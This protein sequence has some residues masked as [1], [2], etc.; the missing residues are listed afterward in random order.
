MERLIY[1]S[2]HV[3]ADNRAVANDIIGMI[4]RIEEEYERNENANRLDSYFENSCYMPYGKRLTDFYN[5]EFD[6]CLQDDEVRTA[7]WEKLE[8]KGIHVAQSATYK[9][10]KSTYTLK[11]GSENRAEIYKLAFA[12]ELDV[13]QTVRLFNEV[14]LDR[15]CNYRDYRE[16]VY[17]YCISRGKTYQDAETIIGEIDAKSANDEG[18]YGSE[19]GS[20]FLQDRVRET[21]TDGDIVDFILSH[22]MLFGERYVRARETVQEL[23]FGV[24]SEDTE[25]ENGD[26]PIGGEN[27][28]V[29]R[30]VNEKPKGSFKMTRRPKTEGFIMYVILYGANDGRVSNDI[31]AKLPK[32]AALNF[33]SREKLTHKSQYSSDSLRKLIILLYFYKKWTTILYVEKRDITKA[34]CKNFYHEMNGILEDCGYSGLYSR[35]PYDRVFIYCTEVTYAY[36]YLSNPVDVLRDLLAT[37]KQDEDEDKD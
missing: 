26:I 32:E 9:W 14:Y 24:E 29:M 21:E 13:P 19:H 28:L 36:Y 33:P 12:L 7:I 4:N 25:D 23:L 3:D 16:Y 22:R 8:E 31:K 18:A 35:N 6:T 34:D 37:P 1:E 30:E 20:V 27:G 10:F 2:T 17:M 15:T 11:Y 5:R